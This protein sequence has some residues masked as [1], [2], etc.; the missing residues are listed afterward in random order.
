MFIEKDFFEKSV[1]PNLISIEDIKDR[2]LQVYKI[3]YKDVGRKWLC[4]CDQAEENIVTA[5]QQN[6]CLSVYE[7][8]SEYKKPCIKIYRNAINSLVKRDILI[9]KKINNKGKKGYSLR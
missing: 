8:V 4:A 9:P 5:L 6:A 1:L 3:I 2:Q 7:I